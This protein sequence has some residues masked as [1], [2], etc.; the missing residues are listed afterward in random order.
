MFETIAM[1]FDLYMA[2]ASPV[3]FLAS[4]LRYATGHPR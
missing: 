3:E 2:V 4:L 1:E